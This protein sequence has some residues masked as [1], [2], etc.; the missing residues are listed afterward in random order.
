MGDAIQARARQAV[1]F[2]AQKLADISEEFGIAVDLE[3]RI[4]P[5]WLSEEAL[6]AI[7]A[8]NA[9]EPNGASSGK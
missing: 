4:A 5:T 6:A 7:E 3:N 9:A 8:R 2:L 1:E